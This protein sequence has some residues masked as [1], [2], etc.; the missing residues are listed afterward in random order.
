MVIFGLIVS[1]NNYLIGIIVSKLLSGT[2]IIWI[3][4]SYNNYRIWII[5]RNNN[6]KPRI[7]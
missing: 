1:D 4:V 3:I 5:V 6:Y 2:I 7:P